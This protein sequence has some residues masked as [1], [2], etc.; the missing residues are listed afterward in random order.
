M[1]L[2]ELKEEVQ[3]YQY[4]EDT[5][6]IDVSLATIIA[7]R[8]KLG[9][10][11]WLIIIGAS[12]GGKSQ[13]LRPLALTDEKFLHRVDDLTENTFLSGLRAKEGEKTSLLDRIG[14]QGMVVISDFT[15]IMSKS[16]ETRASIL[17]QFRMI[18]DGEMT[19][20]SG[21]SPKP[22]K[23]EGYLGV[24]AGSTPSIYS[25]F[26]E[27]SD[28]GERFIYWRM[29][30]FDQKKATELAL[31]RKVFG[32]ELDIK[33]SDLYAEYI[34]DVVQTCIDKTIVLPE[35]VT[36][37][38]IE[39]SMLAERV[40][41][42]AHKDWKGI[43]NKIPVSAMPM[44]IALQ[45]TAIAKGLG[46]IK[47]YESG[48]MQFSEKDL[49]IIDWLG[50][51]LANEENRACLKIMASTPFDYVLTTQTIADKINLDTNIAGIILQNLS[52]V[53]VLQR[54]GGSGGL[55]WK[56]SNQSDYD[57][58]RRIE[59]I[60]GTIEIANRDVTVEE[61]DSYGVA[62]EDEFNSF[63]L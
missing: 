53:G 6:I 18:Y 48:K 60:E 58:V 57:I 30:E 10:P 25:H 24:L 27:V 42:N 41:T 36:K 26:E 29:K 45:L 20:F 40:R 61:G 35:E 2:I 43:V 8:L 4:L 21:N 56:F 7:N 32:R 33:L 12:S 31:S 17:S 11:V 50:Y 38:I 28:M 13:I 14:Q 37:R 47:L 22:L 23:W 54:E 49:S 34:K 59:H 46:A 51:S 1:K 39:V 62:V 3:K 16:P 52:A 19:K 9:D 15:V 5:S 55:Q 44:R 63:G